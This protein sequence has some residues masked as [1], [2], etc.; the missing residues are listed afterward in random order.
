M[1]SSSHHISVFLT[2]LGFDVVLQ[3]GKTARPAR[4]RVA[5]DGSSTELTFK[6]AN[7]DDAYTTVQVQFCDDEDKLIVALDDHEVAVK[8]RPAGHFFGYV[9]PSFEQSARISY[10]EARALAV[11]AGKKAADEARATAKAKGNRKP[12]TSACFEDDIPF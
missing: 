4:C 3:E 2:A 9:H 6:D 12:A 7:G 1:F 8:L 11:A 5:Y 10:A